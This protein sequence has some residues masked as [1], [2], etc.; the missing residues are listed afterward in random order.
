MLQKSSCPP[1]LLHVDT[2]FAKLVN[3]SQSGMF[4]DPA[5]VYGLSDIQH[6]HKWGGKPLRLSDELT[7]ALAT[8]GIHVA[9]GVHC[10]RLT[11]DGIIYACETEHHGNSQVL[12]KNSSN[13]NV[14]TPAIVESILQVEHAGGIQTAIAI[15]R[16]KPCNAQNDPFARYPLLHLSLH[17]SE[18]GALEIV[19]PSAILSH[20]S[21]LKIVWESKDVLIVNSLDRS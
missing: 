6:S 2:F 12:L 11:I 16:L 17:L 13:R 5:D 3:H 4:I 20:F 21:S 18:P 10:S 14:A 19:S 1:A 15:R 9:Q 7:S 8:A